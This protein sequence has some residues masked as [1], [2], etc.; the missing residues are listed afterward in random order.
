[1]STFALELGRVAAKRR[2][3]EKRE[4]PEPLLG[5]EF[6]AD[7]RRGYGGFG[8]PCQTKTHSVVDTAV[9]RCHTPESVATA[10]SKM[11]LV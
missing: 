5:G 2:D 10:T 4:Q 9:E 7:W 1:M 3:A 8:L 11:M 6:L